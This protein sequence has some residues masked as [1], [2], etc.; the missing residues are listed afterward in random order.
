MLHPSEPPHSQSLAA[1]IGYT[2][3]ANQHRLYPGFL[4]TH[5][6][7]LKAH[8]DWHLAGECDGSSPA[9][10][11][12]PGRLLK[13]L[14]HGS[15]PSRVDWY[16]SSPVRCKQARSDDRS[17]LSRY[18]ANHPEVRNCEGFRM[19]AGHRLRSLPRPGRP[20]FENLQ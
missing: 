9:G 12:G 3:A 5:N 20:A 8:V 2:G 6:C 17:Q 10:H 13:Q 7:G 18:G 19:P 16:A 15:N 14:K 11:G 1:R 4:W